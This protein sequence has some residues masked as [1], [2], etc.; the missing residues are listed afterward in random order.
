MK[1]QINKLRQEMEIRREEEL[2]D[3]WGTA[4]LINSFDA[5]NNYFDG[6]AQA[7]RDVERADPA[8]GIDL[9]AEIERIKSDFSNYAD[10]ASLEAESYADDDA[11]EMNQDQAFAEGCAVGYRKA[12]CRITTL[13]DRVNAAVFERELRSV[14][15]QEGDPV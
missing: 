5:V 8:C 9:I 2:K 10:Q 11:D 3:A 14:M 1:K 6:Y 15:D 12:L 4:H 13:L 7:L